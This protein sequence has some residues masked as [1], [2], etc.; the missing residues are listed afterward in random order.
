MTHRLSIV[1]DGSDR[2]MQALSSTRG[3]RRQ[4]H[5]ELVLHFETER[6]DELA[7]SGF[8]RRWALRRKI[9][10]EARETVHREFGI[11]S[12]SAM[13]FQPRPRLQRSA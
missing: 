4:R 2:L 5:L 12:Y 3:A 6:A 10:E 9:R 11:P 7:R 13:F 8:F 1:A